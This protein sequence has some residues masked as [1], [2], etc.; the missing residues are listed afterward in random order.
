MRLAERLTAA[1]S[2]KLLIIQGKYGLDIAA[3]ALAAS[4]AFGSMVKTP[5]RNIFNGFERVPVNEKNPALNSI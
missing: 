2:D 3:R 5:V 1:A 4:A